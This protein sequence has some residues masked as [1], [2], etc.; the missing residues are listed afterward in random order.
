MFH[1]PSKFELSEMGW[2]EVREKKSR[3]LI[4]SWLPQEEQMLAL[5]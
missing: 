4:I 5:N 3:H 2:R 1:D